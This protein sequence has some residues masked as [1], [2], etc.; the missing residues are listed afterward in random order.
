MKRDR[1]SFGIEQTRAQGDKQTKPTTEKLYG[2]NK[3]LF[4]TEMS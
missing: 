4:N 2:I 3:H 1:A